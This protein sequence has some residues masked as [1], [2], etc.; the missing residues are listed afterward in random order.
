MT[1]TPSTASNTSVGAGQM[2]PD[3]SND[4]TSVAAFIV[5]QMVAKL[6]T[7]KLVKVVKVTGG[8]GAIAAA[9][10][11]DVQLLVSQIDGSNNTVP[12][13]VVHGIPWYR[14]AGGNGAIILD[15]KEGDVGFV[16]CSDRDT[17]NVRAAGPGAAAIAAPGSRRQLNV[18]DGIYVG[19]VLNALPEQYIV[20]TEAGI[21]ILDKS[22][23]VIDLTSSGIALTPASG[24]PVT[25]NG[26]LVVT[27]NLQ[28]GGSVLAQAGGTYGGN[29][30]TSG[31]VVAGTIGLK[32]HHHTQAND[33][34]GDT[35]QPT[36]PS[37]A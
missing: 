10:T 35:E 1:D 6:D 2:F 4:E 9:G 22:G 20:F 13:G 34:H 30:A 15:P 14:M 11:V 18:A 29:I 26:P 19:G 12:N 31:E 23:N 32:A 7:M 24:M 21:K 28:L 16:V 8:G 33:S 36:G 17:S 27:G 37:V 25:V 3:D 5:R